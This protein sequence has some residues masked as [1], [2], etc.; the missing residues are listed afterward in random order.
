MSRQFAFCLTLSITLASTQ[1]GL[2]QGIYIPSGGIVNRS[3]AGASTAAPVD[4]IGAM[5]WNPA[6]ISGL[7]NSEIAFGLELLFS[8]A[9]IS[10]SAFGASGSTQD[11]GG[12]SPIPAIGWVHQ[13]P[14]SDLTIGL[15]LFAVAGFQT[16]YPVDATNPILAPQSNTVGVPGGFGRIASEAQFLEMTPAFSFQVTDNIAIGGGPIVTIAKVTAAPF[17]FGAPDDADGSGQARYPNSVGS[18]FHMG[19]GAQ[20]GIYYSG[21]NDVTLGAVVKTPQFM[22][23]FRFQTQDETG[24]GRFDKFDL[25]L[26]MIL[27][28]GAAYHGIQNAV[29]AVD[30]RYF[31]YRNTDGFGDTGFNADGSLRGL[32]WSNTISVAMGGRFRVSDRLTLGLGYQ[33]NPSPIDDVDTIYNLA[34]PLIQEHMVSTGASINLTPAVEIHLSYS[35]F[36]DTSVS[37]P[38]ITALTG[39]I[40]GTSVTQDLSAHFASMGVS[41]KY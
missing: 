6:S 40:A 16:N 39:P 9:E 7:E 27:S 34:A 17:A 30:V 35:Y 14:D 22:E 33:Y 28:V 37:G 11:D 15:G 20:L 8:N 36:F 18:R 41:V 13:I 26:P 3:M 32:S 1:T 38:I 24:A 10:S 2:G 23:Q 5:Y 25:D 19:L 31:D 4:A 12:P 21:L 29:L